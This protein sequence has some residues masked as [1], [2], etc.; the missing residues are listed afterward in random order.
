MRIWDLD[1]DV[2]CD[3]HLLGEHRE[4]HAIWSIL[5]TGKRGYASHPETLRWQGRLPALYARHEAQVAEMERRGFDHASPLDVSL[6][7]GAAEQTVLLDPLDEQRRRLTAHDCA[8]F[9]A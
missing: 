8:C 3:W 9:A 7:V 1:P 5:T 6:A 4:L 2:L